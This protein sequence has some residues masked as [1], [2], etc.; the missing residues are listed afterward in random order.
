M[1][2]GFFSLSR[3]K[4]AAKPTDEGARGVSTCWFRTIGGGF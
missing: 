1:A 4:V 3:E 2:L